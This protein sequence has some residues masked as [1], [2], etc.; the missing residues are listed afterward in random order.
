MIMFPFVIAFSLFL[1]HLPPFFSQ[2]LHPPERGWLYDRSPCSQCCI[3]RRS[4]WS[5]R[6]SPRGDSYMEIMRKGGGIVNT[7]KATR[8]AS[9][10]ELV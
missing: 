10:E 7:V 1:A 9:K 2:D 4:G 6:F 5:S 3:Q 8:K